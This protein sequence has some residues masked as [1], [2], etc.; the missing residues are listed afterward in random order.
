[1]LAAG[2]AGLLALTA[3]TGCGV[4]EPF[5]HQSF[6]EQFGPLR[7]DDGRVTADS[8]VPVKYLEVG[9]CFDFPDGGDE[10]RATI[11]PC[12]EDHVFEVIATGTI[13]LQQQQTLGLQLAIT[14]ACGQPFDDWSATRPADRRKD[15][16]SLV[17]D[18]GGDSQAKLYTCVAALQRLD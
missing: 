10:S 4:V 11:R 15:Y 13:D 2:A 17:R 7:G 14:R 12:G 1:V 5:L 8:D 9:D 16:E 6:P 18:A 3:L